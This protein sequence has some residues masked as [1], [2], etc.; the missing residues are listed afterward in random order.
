MIAPELDL[1]P[2][3]DH[4]IKRAC[5]KQFRGLVARK[6]RAGVVR[7]G[8]GAVLGPDKR[9]GQTRRAARFPPT[10]LAFPDTSRLGSNGS[11]QAPPWTRIWERLRQAGH[12]NVE[13]APAAACFILLCL[14]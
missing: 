12:E 11:Q 1:Q 14:V 3:G 9:E 4:C 6:L 7:V 8:L 10:Q 5:L 2:I 13:S